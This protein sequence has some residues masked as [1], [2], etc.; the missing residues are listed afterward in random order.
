MDPCGQ[1]SVQ[2]VLG[3]LCKT[4]GQSDLV[5]PSMGRDQD[6][7]E[8][9]DKHEHPAI[10]VHSSPAVVEYS[11]SVVVHPSSQAVDP[12]AE[13]VDHNGGM[14]ETLETRV[15]LVEEELARVGMVVELHLRTMA[16]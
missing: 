12:S 16:C 4:V 13:E 2:V 14:M 7:P 9:V 11:P 15:E 10:H 8:M 1:I 6:H 5:G 3:V